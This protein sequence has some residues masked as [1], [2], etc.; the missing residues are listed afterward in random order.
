M[1]L[2]ATAR[3]HTLTIMAKAVQRLGHSLVKPSA[4]F[5]PTAHAI[6]KKPA[7]TR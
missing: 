5:N 3:H 2:R 4:Y 7:M 1:V 6:S